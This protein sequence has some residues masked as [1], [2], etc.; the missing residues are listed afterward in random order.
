MEVGAV[1][2]TLYPDR[3]SAVQGIQ[4]NNGQTGSTEIQEKTITNTTNESQIRNA[5]EN[6]NKKLKFTRTKCELT[7]H[8][9]I[10]RVAIK[11]I[12]KETEEVIREIPPEE[13]L[14]LVKKLWEMAGIII[15][16][17]R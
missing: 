16:E 11:V 3:L 13:T 15:D 12:D 2:G 8:E 5:I 9:D 7:Y 10:N 14:E 6:A 17:K 4:N 1:S